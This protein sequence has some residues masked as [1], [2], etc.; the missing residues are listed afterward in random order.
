MED[1]AGDGFRAG[2]GLVAEAGGLTGLGVGEARDFAGEDQ[3]AVV[4]EGHAV[5]GGEA[6][7][8]FTDEVDVGR[9]LE[10]EAGGLDGIAEALD[11]GDAAGFH[12]AAVHEEGVE[13]DAAVGGEEAAAA[14]VEGGV[15]F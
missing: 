7:R 3:L 15:V 11:A 12:A 2:E 6:F 13:L 5:S 14:G 9:L 4:D 8:A 1:V 10:D